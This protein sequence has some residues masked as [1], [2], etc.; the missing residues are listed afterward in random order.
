MRHKRQ[1]E[2]TSQRAAYLIRAHSEVEL[3]MTTQSHREQLV[4]FSVSFHGIPRRVVPSA[5]K[6]RQTESPAL[7]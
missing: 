4:L 2:K 3:N 6:G 7:R 1:G 5:C